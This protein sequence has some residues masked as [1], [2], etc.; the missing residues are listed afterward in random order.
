MVRF[1]F[2]YAKFNVSFGGVFS[3]L[4]LHHLE[5]LVSQ[6]MRTRKRT[7]DEMYWLLTFLGHCYFDSI[8]QNYSC[9]P[10]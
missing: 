7:K 1:I 6:F 2:T 3:I 8:G 9:G 4:A 5:C 10:I